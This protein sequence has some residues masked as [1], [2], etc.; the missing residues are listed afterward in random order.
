MITS[1]SSVSPVMPEPR[2][3]AS[4]FPPVIQIYSFEPDPKYNINPVQPLG[5]D[6]MDDTTARPVLVAQLDMPRFAPGVIVSSFD[7]RPDPAFAPRDPSDPNLCPHKPFTQNPGK[8]LVV[9]DLHVIEP[10]D[11]PEEMIPDLLGQES[12]GFELF[13]LRETLVTLANEGEERLKTVRADNGAD[14]NQP[15][16]VVVA[17]AWSEWGEHSSRM[18]DL[19][20]KRR[21]WVGRDPSSSDVLINLRYV[22]VPATALPL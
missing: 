9:I 12:I 19:S 8:G 3:I 15:W 18:M 21:Q 13:I 2:S 6:Y 7:I 10:G 11:N 1:T 14:G 22:R 20:M 17:L 4:V 16:R 5:F